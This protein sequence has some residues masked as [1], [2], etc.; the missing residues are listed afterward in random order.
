MGPTGE[1][2]G[3]ENDQV[4]M[5]PNGRAL[6]T[7]SQNAVLLVGG[8]NLLPEERVRR[9]DL[10]TQTLDVVPIDPL[11]TPSAQVLGATYDAFRSLL[12][13]L[14]TEEGKARLA[15]HD[16]VAKTSRVLWLAPDDALYDSTY[17]GR[18]EWGRLVLGVADA[19]ATT[20]WTL[21]IRSGEVVFDS[22][23][24][25]A[26]RPASAPAMGLHALT[27]PVIGDDGLTY[28]ELAPRFFEEGAPCTGL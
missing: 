18:T 23:L 11:F 7:A 5:P 27:L 14:D 16:L 12:Y 24:D 8:S 9:Y 19:A 22:R 26:G 1:I 28:V 2:P 15:E 21:D 4:R 13:I 10:G 25:I 20:F 17:L 3:Y 6:F